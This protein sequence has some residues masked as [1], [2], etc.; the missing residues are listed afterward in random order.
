M[1]DNFAVVRQRTAACV[2][3]Y[4]TTNN[5]TTLQPSLFAVV[6]GVLV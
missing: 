4:Y 2:F 3:C 1:T 6:T 5:I